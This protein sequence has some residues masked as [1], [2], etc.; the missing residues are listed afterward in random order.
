M[1]QLAEALRYMPEGRGFDSVRCHWNF[2]LKQFFQF[3]VAVRP[4]Q[5]LRE[6]STKNILWGVKMAGAKG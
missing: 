1:V 3:I 5:P 2:S 6:M 4:T